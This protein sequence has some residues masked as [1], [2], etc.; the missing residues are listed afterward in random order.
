MN[1]KNHITLSF[2]FLL[3]GGICFYLLI[4]YP[5]REVLILPCI[6]CSVGAGVYLSQFLNPGYIE[7]E[8]IPDS[9]VFTVLKIVDDEFFVIDFN[10]KRYLI[11]DNYKRISSQLSEN[12]QYHRYGDIVR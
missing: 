9:K 3:I 1:R 8:D 5:G 10:K 6:I 12:K 7:F 4:V 2:L 11:R